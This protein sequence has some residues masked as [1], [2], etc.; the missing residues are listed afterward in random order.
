MS[1]RQVSYSNTFSEWMIVTNQTVARLNVLDTG[2]YEKSN[3]TFLLTSNTILDVGNTAIFRGNTYFLGDMYSNANS[4]FV[5]IRTGNLTATTNTNLNKLYVS[6]RSTLADVLATDLTATGTI[7]FTG[8]TTIN[9]ADLLGTTIIDTTSIGVATIAN[10]T[11]GNLTVTSNTTHTGTGYLKLPSGTTA[12][13]PSG[14]TVGR[15]R[16]NTT[17]TNFE[18][19]DSDGWKR[20]GGGKGGGTDSIF[21]EN[22]QIISDDYTLTSFKNYITA[23]PI[24]VANNKTVTIPDYCYWTIV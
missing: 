21:I 6:G 1:I 16:Y 5:S 10:T 12:Q 9:N 11:I 15:I 4:Y 22:D 18:G 13:R 14:T 19:R 3:G 24:S 8:S 17:T 20:L 23:G 7:N 2:Y